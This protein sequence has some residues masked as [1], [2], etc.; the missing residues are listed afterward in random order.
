MV[1]N[2]RV[3]EINRGARKLTR[4]PMLIIIKK[5]NESLS[6]KKNKEESVFFSFNRLRGKTMEI[7]IIFS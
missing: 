2:F 1:V 7:I 6:I 4:T 5:L 3:C